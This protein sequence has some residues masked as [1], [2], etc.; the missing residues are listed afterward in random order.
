T[1]TSWAKAYAESLVSALDARVTGTVNSH[2]E[3]PGSKH[4]AS[5]ISYNTTNVGVAIKAN[6]DAI[7]EIGTIARTHTHPKS[8]ITDFPTTMTPEAHT[9]LTTEIVNFPTTMT[10]KSHT[11]P[12]TEILN[13]P[14]SM[15]PKPHTHVKADILDLV[16]TPSVEQPSKPLLT[17]LSPVGTVVGTPAW[18]GTGEFNTNATTNNSHNVLGFVDGTVHFMRLSL[19]L[20]NLGDWQDWAAYYDY[21]GKA[22]EF[23]YSETRGVY[24]GLVPDE[25]LTLQTVINKIRWVYKRKPDTIVYGD[26]NGIQYFEI[27]WENKKHYSWTHNPTFQRRL[28]D[29]RH[30]SIPAPTVEGIYPINDSNVFMNNFNSKCPFNNFP[31]SIVLKAKFYLALDLDGDNQ[32]ITSDTS[33]IQQLE[34]GITNFL[35]ID[36]IDN[37]AA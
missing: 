10:P 2:I 37:W 32:L 24:D 6:A 5:A 9:H 27:D 20:Q 8:A 35:P 1:K 11:H 22:Y 26:V 4:N 13:F 36:T 25:S 7:T 19:R 16:E 17:A 15:P 3:G 33:N 23:F 12:T 31:G 34:C 30:D 29:G 28:G 21:N 14:I 18:T